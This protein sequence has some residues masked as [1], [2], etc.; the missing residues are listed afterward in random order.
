MSFGSS[1]LGIYWFLGSSLVSWSSCKQSSIAQSTIVAG[2]QHMLFVASC[3]FVLLWMKA[4]LRYF[5]LYFESLPLLFDRTSVISVEYY[6]ILYSTPKPN[7]QMCTSTYEE[8]TMKRVALIFAMQTPKT[9]LQTYLQKPINQVIFCSLAR[10]TRCLLPFLEER[11]F[12]SCILVFYSIFVLQPIFL[13]L[14]HI[15]IASHHVLQSILSFMCISLRMR[16]Y[17]LWYVSCII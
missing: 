11:S 8:I 13:L 17:C 4:T 5:R 3:C 16:L 12:G 1:T 15:C 2:Q 6:P 7:I 9:S 14:Y 10:W